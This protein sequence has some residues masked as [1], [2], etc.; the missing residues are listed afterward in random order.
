MCI[1]KKCVNNKKSKNIRE[2]RGKIKFSDGYDYKM[3]RNN[4]RDSKCM[5]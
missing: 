4:S 3:M 2:L 1:V 5:S